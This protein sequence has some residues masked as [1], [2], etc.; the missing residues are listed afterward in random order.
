M[1]VLV[2]LCCFH[3]RGGSRA[4]LELVVLLRRYPAGSVI[5]VHADEPIQDPLAIDPQAV[6]F[7]TRW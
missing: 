4:A 1:G 3:G 6:V 2:V 5:P 7:R